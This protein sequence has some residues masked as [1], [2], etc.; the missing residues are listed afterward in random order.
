[1]ELDHLAE[2]VAERQTTPDR[3]NWW[4]GSAMTKTHKSRQQ[5]A[6]ADTKNEV[7]AQKLQLG[8]GETRLMQRTSF[9]RGRNECKTETT[10]L[11]LVMGE[12]ASVR[13]ELDARLR[14]LEALTRRGN[15]A[16][17]GRNKRPPKE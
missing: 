12:P 11:W 7:G 17:G 13:Q 1:M 3:P 8:P 16:L 14:A 4:H 15:G 10:T 2:G 6:H 9:R 5:R